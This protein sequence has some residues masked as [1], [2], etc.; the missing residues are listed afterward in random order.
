MARTKTT[1]FFKEKNGTWTIDTK[2]KVDGEWRHLKRRGY[3]SLSE[4][5][6]GLEK[7]KEKYAVSHHSVMFFDN[8]IDEYEKSRRYIVN[9]STLESDQSTFKIHFLPFFKGRLLR[10]VLNANFISEWYENL[11]DDEK[12]SNGVKSKVITRMKDVL[13]FAYMHKYI[14]AEA[15]QDCDVNLYQIKHTKKPLSERVI[16][17]YNEEEAFLKAI[18][19]DKRDSLLF[20][21]FLTTS[22]RLGEFLG[23]KPSCFDYEKKKIIICQQVKNVKGKG[24]VLTDRL[25]TNESY[26]SISVSQELADELRDYIKDFNIKED[27]YLWFTFSKNK[28]MARNTI[29]RLFDHYCKKAGVRRMN[30]HALRHNQAVKLA[31]VC[32]TGAELEVAARR[33]GH[34][35]AMFMNT[36]AN[37]T[38][39]QKELEL[40]ER[41]SRV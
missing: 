22:P 6:D 11:I 8:L 2:V 29:R 32:R 10:D 41:I 30:L 37:H 31:S 27:Q 24:A 20:R 40:L 9:E 15:Y 3:S 12:L 18:S 1:G 25:K 23:L 39:D 19:K 26:R 5:K 17:T 14:D 38:N 21:V 36:Y 7:E 33:L 16:W 4:A 35:P 28:P 13:K 34:S